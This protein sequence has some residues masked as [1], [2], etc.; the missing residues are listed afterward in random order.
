M[1]H[2]YA[3]LSTHP[4]SAAHVSLFSIYFFPH[5]VSGQSDIAYFLSKFLATI[6]FYMRENYVVSGHGSMD[7]LKDQTFK[8]P[9]QPRCSNLLF[10]NVEKQIFK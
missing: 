2:T 1:W 9:S 8:V 5:W 4:T 10:V 3:S 6:L 7:S